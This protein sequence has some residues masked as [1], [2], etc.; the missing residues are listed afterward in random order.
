M[1][2]PDLQSGNQKDKETADKWEEDESVRKA[3]ICEE[4]KGLKG[5]EVEWRRVGKERRAD[6]DRED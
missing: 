1:E 2:E 5:G 3:I 6:R 4:G